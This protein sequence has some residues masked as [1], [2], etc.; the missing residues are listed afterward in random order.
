MCP[1][2]L[3]FSYMSVSR[4]CVPVP[5]NGRVNRR[6]RSL[7][8]LEH[9]SHVLGVTP[10]LSTL[11]TCVTWGHAWDSLSAGCPW[12]PSRNPMMI[13]AR[14]CLRSP[15]SLTT[16]ECVKM[17]VVSRWLSMEHRFLSSGS[18]LIVI[19]HCTDTTNK[20]FHVWQKK[21][22]WVVKHTQNIYDF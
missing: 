17:Q 10:R 11:G 3:H 5:V 13:P 7:H 18:P 6:K 12:Q 9:L 16:H 22:Q 4:N 21:N 15:A 8:L 20:L 2:T 1:T 19:R 14:P